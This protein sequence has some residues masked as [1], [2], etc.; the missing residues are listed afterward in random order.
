M[1]EYQQFH[2]KTRKAWRR[3]LE[4]NHA[5]EPGVWFVYYKKETGKPRVSYEDSVLEALCF[6]WI[7]STA[8]R[9]D[10]ERAILTFTPRKNGSVW[11]Q[12]NKMR[13]L[14]LQK[15]GLMQA[16]GQAKIDQAI[17]DG[18]WEKLTLTDTHATDNTM[19]DDLAQA[20]A[21]NTKARDHFSA[22]ARSY[23]RQFLFWIDSAKRPETR[24][25]R[26]RMTV[27]MSAANK[28]PGIDGFKL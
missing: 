22:F 7:D 16:P 12:P 17:K 1:A 24:K 4:K 19:P 21:K 28:K 15:L 6:G 2:P 13:I 3:W 23:R 10:D 14:A 25:D 26:I 9:L 8:R 20:L 11:S 5:K 18:S 27:K